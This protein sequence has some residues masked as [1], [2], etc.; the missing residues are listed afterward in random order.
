VGDK[1]SDNADVLMVPNDENRSWWA[2]SWLSVSKLLTPFIGKVRGVGC[3]SQFMIWIGQ[4]SRY[5]RRKRGWEDFDFPGTQ[6]L[7]DLP[8]EMP[9]IVHCHNLHGGYFDLRALPWLSRQVPVVFTLHDAWLLSGYCAHSFDCELWETGC[10]Q[11][12]DLT[13]YPA[14][15]RDA[16]AYN[17]QRK[18]D[19]YAQSRLYVATPSQ[20]L[21]DKVKRS[22]LASGIVE[23][24]VIHNGIDLSIFH[25]SGGRAAREALGL[26][27][28]AKIILFAANGIRRN[29]WKDYET[30][31]TAIARAAEQWDGEEILFLAL[32]EDAPPEYLGKARVQF[33]PYQQDPVVVAKFYQA[34]DVYIHAARADTFPNTVLEALAC[35]TP[36]VAT[37]VGGIPEQVKSFGIANCE[38]NNHYLD[39][40]TGSLVPPKSPEAMASCIQY[41]L[42]DEPLRKRLGENAARDARNRFDLSRQ[43][44]DYL[45]WYKEILK[46]KL[47]NEL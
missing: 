31:R 23:A 35:G 34:A 36:V 16:T 28:E 24:R 10:G 3:L 39:E 5:I 19:I 29:I 44:S 41:L 20:W 15:K 45:S 12:P 40:A 37:A 11:C 26:P 17:W 9:D 38:R 13:I 27:A 21:M 1:R 30:M 47:Q 14:I 32:G 46:R 6:R 22:I 25:P 8:P 7:L 43:V 4:P 33:V 2:R 42:N 18:R